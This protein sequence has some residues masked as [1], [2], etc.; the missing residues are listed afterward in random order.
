[1]EDDVF[2]SYCDK[3][4]QFNNLPSHKLVFCPDC[5]L[6][7]TKGKKNDRINQN[8][9]GIKYSSADDDRNSESTE[10]QNKR[11]FNKLKILLLIITVATVSVFIYSYHSKEIP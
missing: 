11:T 2:C 10:V 7:A 4:F 9:L 1:M 6:G 3:L 8:P 5:G